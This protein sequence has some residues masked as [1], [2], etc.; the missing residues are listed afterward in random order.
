MK[1]SCH[2]FSGMRPPRP[3]FCPQ[4]VYDLMHKCWA[5]EPDKRVTAE[6]ILLDPCLETQISDN[7]AECP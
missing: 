7:P 3:R 4:G 6:D 2:L 1:I 5:S